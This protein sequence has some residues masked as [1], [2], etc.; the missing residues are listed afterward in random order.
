MFRTKFYTSELIF[1]R[2]CNLVDINECDAPKLN[3]TTT[4]KPSTVN[5]LV[6]VLLS[7][8]AS[9]CVNPKKWAF[10]FSRVPYSICCLVICLPSSDNC[11]RYVFS[12]GSRN[13]LSFLTGTLQYVASH[14]WSKVASLM[15]V[16]GIS[17][18]PDHCY[19]MSSSL[20]CLLVLVEPQRVMSRLFIK[21]CIHILYISN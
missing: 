16:F 18:C 10:S 17:P 15:K 2:W 19:P 7:L 5:I 4:S 8:A 1:F 11:N 6:I 13:K 14:T 3:R 20:D 9:S 12:H 21:I